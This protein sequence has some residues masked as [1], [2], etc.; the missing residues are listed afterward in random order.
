MRTGQAILTSFSEKLPR[1]AQENLRYL[2]K[3]QKEKMEDGS[4]PSLACCPHPILQVR[5]VVGHPRS[6][7]RAGAGEGW[8]FWAEGE[9]L[10]KVYF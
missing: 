1:A 7:H 10:A 3:L 6:A 8:Y 2:T 9:N 5:V 4:S